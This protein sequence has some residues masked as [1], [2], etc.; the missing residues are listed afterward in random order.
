MESVGVLSLFLFLLGR[1]FEA[2][3]LTADRVHP[4]ADGGV[5]L[6]AHAAQ[7]LDVVGLEETLD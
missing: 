7:F 3:G 2:G 6:L 5:Q 4:F 1:T